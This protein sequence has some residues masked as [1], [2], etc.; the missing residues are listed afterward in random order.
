MALS[1]VGPLLVVFLPSFDY[2]FDV[3]DQFWNFVFF[4][5]S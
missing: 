5:L 4:A 1:S 3:S 2:M